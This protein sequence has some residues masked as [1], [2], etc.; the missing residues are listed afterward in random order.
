MLPPSLPPVRCLLLCAPLWTACAAPPPPVV[1]TLR[2]DVPPSL[3]ACLPQPEPPGAGADDP[4]LARWVL[5][6]AEAGE[7]CRTRLARVAEVVA[8]P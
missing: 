3:L 4:T 7:D 1:Q 8:A 5:D 2:L 6:L